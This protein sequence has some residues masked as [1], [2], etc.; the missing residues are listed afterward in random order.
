MYQKIADLE[1]RLTLLLEVLPEADVG[2]T[3]LDTESCTILFTYDDTNYTLVIKNEEPVKS[4][5]GMELR[6]ETKA[7]QFHGQLINHLQDN[8]YNRLIKID[9]PSAMVLKGVNLSY[10]PEYHGILKENTLYGAL[11]RFATGKMDVDKT[12]NALSSYEFDVEKEIYPLMNSLGLVRDDYEEGIKIA[13]N[14]GL[15]VPVWDNTERTRRKGELPPRVTMD[16]QKLSKGTY[17]IV[18]T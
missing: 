13:I 16:H 4:I 6:L 12:A 14:H 15:F 18:R 7:N 10:L 2:K 1:K 8:L 3:K 9:N 11:V 5:T 17:L